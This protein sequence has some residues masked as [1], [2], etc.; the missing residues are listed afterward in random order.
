MPD[1]S[2]AAQETPSP[3]SPDALRFAIAQPLEAVV[4]IPPETYAAGYRVLL[5]T[6]DREAYHAWGYAMAHFPGTFPQATRKARVQAMEAAGFR[7]VRVAIQAT[8]LRS[9][10]V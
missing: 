10:R 4:N 9:A 5:D 8:I 1:D 6:V 2:Q 7:L 3:R